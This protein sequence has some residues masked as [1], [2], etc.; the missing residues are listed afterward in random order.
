[1]L[2]YGYKTKKYHL[3]RKGLSRWQMF[4]L[5]LKAMNG[6]CLTPIKGTHH[7]LRPWQFL[8]FSPLPQGH[9]SLRPTVFSAR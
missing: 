7:A 8:Y 9:G 2:Y 6:L 5:N 4:I 1:M 3:E